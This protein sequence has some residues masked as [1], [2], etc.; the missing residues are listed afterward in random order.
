MQD[1]ESREDIF[2]LVTT[3]YA[4]IRKHDL[5]GPIFN[6]AISDWDRHFEHLTDFWESQLLFT[7]RFKGN[8]PKAHIDVD[9]A[10][11]GTITEK[12]FGLWLNEWFATIDELFEGDIAERA[13]HNARKLSTFLYL[14]IWQARKTQKIQEGQNLLPTTLHEWKT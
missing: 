3:F 4:K 9:K 14:Q 2:R 12:H 6:E 5:L 13:K 10:E 8:P 11:G 7:K 1:I